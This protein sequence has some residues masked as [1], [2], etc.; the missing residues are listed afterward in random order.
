MSTPYRAT[1]HPNHSSKRSTKWLHT[2]P[3]RPRH[4]L[5][6]VDLNGDG[7]LSMD[8]LEAAIEGLGA[9]DVLVDADSTSRGMDF[10][11]VFLETLGNVAQM[12]L[13]S[14]QHHTTST[15]KK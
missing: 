5:A 2:S 15:R 3:T 9:G 1:K 12:S 10:V 7:M 11:V 8:E 6:Q 13:L 14:V 4:P